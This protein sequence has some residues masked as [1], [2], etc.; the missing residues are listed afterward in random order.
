MSS[1]S[2]GGCLGESLYSSLYPFRVIQRFSEV[3]AFAGINQSGD[4]SNAEEALR[5]GLTVTSLEDFLFDLNTEGLCF[6]VWARTM[7]LSVAVFE[8]PMI[9]DDFHRASYSA[10]YPTG[11]YLFRL[12]NI[13]SMAFVQLDE[14][15]FQSSAVRLHQ[16]DLQFTAQ[17]SKTS[18]NCLLDIIPRR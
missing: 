10:T 3:L 1:Y 17:I 9:S 18:L 8:R 2:S 5:P 14:S 13:H 4:F 15:H 7:N 6:P 11:L 16:A 12:Q